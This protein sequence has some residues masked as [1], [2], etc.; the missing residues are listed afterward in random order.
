MGQIRSHEPRRLPHRISFKRRQNLH[1][2]P[3]REKNRK[4]LLGPLD[5]NP[6][7]HLHTRQQVPNLSRRR[8]LNK[9]LGL[10]RPDLAQI[11]PIRFTIRHFPLPQLFLQRV[12]ADSILL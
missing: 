9:T 6:L 1:R 10:E 7:L 8:P 12:Q 3:N 5:F 4:L 2:Q 11:K